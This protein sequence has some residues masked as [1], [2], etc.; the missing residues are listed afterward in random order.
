M[1]K[2][3]VFTKCEEEK[4]KKNTF[5]LLGLTGK[6]KSQIIRFLSGNPNVIVSNS[7]SS[8]TK[9]AS[10]YYGVIQIDSNHEEFFCLIDTAGL[11]DSKGPK[12]DEKNYNDIKNIL[13]YNKCEIKGIFMVE[14]FQDERMN[15]E[16]K[17]IIEAACDLFPL[18]N[19]CQYLSIIYTHYYN[20]G[21]T[22]RVK[23]KKDQQAQLSNS[24][25][26]ILENV[27]SER[28]PNIDVDEANIHKL[29][30]NIENNII[31]KKDFDMDDEEEK[32]LYE[33]GLKDLEKAKN[34][35]Y[36]E[37]LE[38]IK[39]EPIYDKIEDLGKEKIL[40]RKVKDSYYNIY[41][42]FVEIRNFYLKGELI[43]KDIISCSEPVLKE[44]IS[45]F[46]YNLNYV[47]KG[48][49]FGELVIYTQLGNGINLLLGKKNDG[50]YISLSR[51]SKMLFPDYVENEKYRKKL[52]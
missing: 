7:L 41:E 2:N 25:K 51:L 18:K 43:Y 16:E 21:S 15:G 48:V 5:I 11:C 1:I 28:I 36:K 35:L 32:E 9:Y 14:N 12:Q 46:S 47:R 3:R 20:K 23:I 13:L 24:L 19:F 34:E 42:S 44:T 38:K 17:K 31:E 39:K 10:L 37:L 6:G 26:E 45:K 30:I 52:Y 4:A 40:I 27:K 49:I 29:Y 8:C 22:S 50:A 33:Q